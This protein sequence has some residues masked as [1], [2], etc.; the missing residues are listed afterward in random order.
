MASSASS[1]VASSASSAAASA[2]A[3]LAAAR[4]AAKASAL[5]ARIA[6]LE[7]EAL[8]EAYIIADNQHRILQREYVKLG[9][10]YFSCK[11]KYPDVV[12]ERVI[13]EY[14]ACGANKTA[15]H[16]AS[17]AAM[18]AQEQA[19]KAVVEAYEQKYLF[20]DEARRKAHIASLPALRPSG[21]TV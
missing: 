9:K 1:A 20:E 15:A 13:R 11:N 3:K 7:Y 10:E 8:W 19:K 12:R 17:S 16:I 2:A 14:V 21:T 18:L 5:C 6:Q 4:T